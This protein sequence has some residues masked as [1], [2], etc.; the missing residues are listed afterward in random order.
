LC[1]LAC[2]FFRYSC[3]SPFLFV[4]D[5]TFSVVYTRS[6]KSHSSVRVFVA[7]V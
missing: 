6:V 4:P 2:F 7:S 1:V 3:F 5:P